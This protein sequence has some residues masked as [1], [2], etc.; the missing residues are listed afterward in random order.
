MS[1]IAKVLLCSM[2]A[3]L[4]QNLKGSEVAGSSSVEKLDDTMEKQLDDMGYSGLVG[5]TV[6]EQ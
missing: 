4:A 1:A 6:S 3:A 5:L 2:V